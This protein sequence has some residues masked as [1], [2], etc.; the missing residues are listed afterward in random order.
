LFTTDN[1][2]YVDATLKLKARKAF[3]QEE[4]Q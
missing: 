3:A 1:Y 4:A 2:D